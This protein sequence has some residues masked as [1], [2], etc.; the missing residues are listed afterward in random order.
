MIERK[1]VMKDLTKEELLSLLK[2]YDGYIQDAND[3][4]LYQDGW[5]PV[6]IEEFYHNDYE[7][8]RG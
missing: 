4:D 6:C 8:W 2:A 5:K 3:G 1:A 7:D